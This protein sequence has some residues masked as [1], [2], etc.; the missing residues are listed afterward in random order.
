[1][2]SIIDARTRDPL[3]EGTLKDDVLTCDWHNWKFNLRDGACV[4]G[5][6]DVRLYPIRVED[7]GVF[8]ISQTST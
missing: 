4:H 2:P 6:E 8:W 7:G 1:M 5:G 3:S